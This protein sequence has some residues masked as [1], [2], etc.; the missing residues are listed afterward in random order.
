MTETDNNINDNRVEGSIKNF[1]QCSIDINGEVVE[2]IADPDSEFSVITYEEAKEPGLEIDEVSSRIDDINGMDLTRQVLDKE[3][4]IYLRELLEIIKPEIRQ[5]IINFIADPN[6][7]KKR[8]IPRKKS[9][10]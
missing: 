4:Q 1:N 10:Y 3:I 2:G 6:T 9:K 8:K 7:I 5:N